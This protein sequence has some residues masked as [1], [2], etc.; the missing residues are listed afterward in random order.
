MVLVSCHF[1]VGLEL[2]NIGKN[3]LRSLNFFSFPDALS[4]FYLAN[5][6]PKLHTWAK[7][8]LLLVYLLTW[9]TWK[10]YQNP[11]Q[12]IEREKNLEREYLTRPC[13]LSKFV[14]L[15]PIS[16]V[17][18]YLK[19]QGYEDIFP[20]NIWRNTA[21]ILHVYKYWGLCS[22]YNSYNFGNDLTLTKYLLE[23][24]LE[25]KKSYFYNIFLTNLKW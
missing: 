11:L 7:L 21:I 6:V 18:D 9:H 5:L 3:V 12:S 24:Y 2:D 22:N 10:N 17:V 15:Q 16:L 25:K 23:V 13:H 14:D 19:V 1:L 20:N 8:L 4:T